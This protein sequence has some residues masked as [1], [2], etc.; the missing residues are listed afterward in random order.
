MLITKSKYVEYRNCPRKFWFDEFE[1]LPSNP[2]SASEEGTKVGAIARDYFGKDA[3]KYVGADA[4]SIP[5]DP[6]LYAEY[7]FKHSVDKDNE[8]LCLVDILRINDDGTVDIIEVKSA[9][10]ENEEEGTNDKKEVLKDFGYDV[11]FQ[12]YVAVRA[13]VKVNRIYVMTINKDY[14][15]DGVNLDLRQL[16][17]LFD[18][19]DEI[20]AKEDEV[21]KAVEEMA[22]IDASTPPDCFY[23]GYCNK[24][25]GCQYSKRCR[26]IW[27]IP[28]DKSILD[29]ASFSSKTAKKF[30]DAELRSYKDIYSSGLWEELSEY[31]KRLINFTM[32]GIDK[33]YVN[34]EA[35]EKWLKKV[36]APLYFFDFE[37]VSAAIPVYAKSRPYQQIPFQYSLH[38]MNSDGENISIVKAAHKEFLG[39][40]VNDPRESLIKQMIEDL[41]TKGKIVAY[42]MGF[43]KARIRELSRDFPAYSKKLMKIHDRFIDLLDVFKS[44]ISLGKYYKAK[45][46]VDLYGNNVYEEADVSI[47][48]S[49]VYYPGMKGSNSI[50]AVL[51]SMFPGDPDY[52]YHN[53]SQVHKGDEASAAYVS[54]GNQNMDPNDKEVLR[55]NM[56]KYCCLDTFAMV[57]IYFKLKEL[58][59]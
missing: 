35:L 34:K 5:T 50:K 31:N 30:Y 41:G 55:G 10:K 52:D 57:A 29:L 24:Y 56:L 49:I 16:F 43:E 23:S 25:A 33:P 36:K 3:A 32:L 42:N 19:T 38:I 18:V 17:T 13:G 9:S 4:K 6:G 40:G 37:T 1:K 20:K 58:I 15:Y 54:L 53:L 44:K 7:P 45:K 21:N 2:T 46:A 26:G 28:Q 39:D 48:T 14:V 59:E 51:P 12:N 22:K 11:S 47:S 27:G 8:L